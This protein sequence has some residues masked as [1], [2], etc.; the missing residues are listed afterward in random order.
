[1]NNIIRWMTHGQNPIIWKF[2]IVIFLSLTH[3]SDA[4]LK[5]EFEKVYFSFVLLSVT[6]STAA[7][8]MDYILTS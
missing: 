6:L 5:F 3:N 4:N 1:M 7:K 8:Q 2:K